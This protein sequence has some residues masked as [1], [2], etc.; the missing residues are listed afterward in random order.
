MYAACV[1]GDGDDRMAAGSGNIS[2]ELFRGEVV[3]TV[4]IDVTLSCSSRDR[5]PCAHW[6][7]GSWLI[8]RWPVKCSTCF[9]CFVFFS[10]CAK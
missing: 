4:G 1:H 9:F 5:D 2:N 7:R 8:A 6:L 10:Y 3:T